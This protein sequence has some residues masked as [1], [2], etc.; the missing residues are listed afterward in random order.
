[1]VVCGH[2]PL[3]VLMQLLKLILTAACLGKCRIGLIRF[4]VR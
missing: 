4:L 2:G 3:T 1:M